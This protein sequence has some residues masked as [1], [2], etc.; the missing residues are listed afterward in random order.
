MPNIQE[1]CAFRCCFLVNV[2]RTVNDVL[3]RGHLFRRSLVVDIECR[4][5]RIRAVCATGENER[6]GDNKSVC[7]SIHREFQTIAHG[8]NIQLGRPSALQ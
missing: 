3:A 4:G 6:H 5:G 7:R 8:G 2:S 1:I